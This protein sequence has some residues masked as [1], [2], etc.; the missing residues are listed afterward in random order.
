KG[1]C[2]VAG[3]VALVFCALLFFWICFT[4]VPANAIGVRTLA[5][6]GI[7]KRD[8]G[9]GFVLCVPGLHTVRLW[10]P[11]WT[12]VYQHM[13][14]RGKDQYKT[15]VDVSVIFRIHKDKCHEV[16]GKFPSYTRIQNLVLTS[17]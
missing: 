11:T 16:A 14:V 3:A 8:Y 5:N 10:D 15:T 7:E 17:L 2:Y 13:E 9:P 4:K 12:N 1:G 6:G